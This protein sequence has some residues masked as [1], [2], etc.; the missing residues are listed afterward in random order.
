MSPSTIV[1]EVPSNKIEAGKRPGSADYNKP[2]RNIVK[3][4]NRNSEY[5]WQ[6]ALESAHRSPPSSS[7]RPA[8]DRLRPRK[9]HQPHARP[10]A[11]T[12]LNHPHHA[13]HR[14]EN[15]QPP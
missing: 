2:P 8:T 4:S 9:T 12:P 13:R 1:K 11:R 3:V 15:L 14:Q 5:L 10:R 7:P 6:S